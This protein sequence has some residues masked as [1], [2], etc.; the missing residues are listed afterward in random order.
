MSDL[1]RCGDHVLHHPTGE[2]WVV[3][4]AEGDDLAWAGWPNG[5]ARLADCTVIKHC[6]DAEH[7]RAVQ[8]WAD[9][10][11]GDSRRPRVLRLYAAVL[12]LTP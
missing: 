12:E 8:E 3:A 11:R 2:E 5:L 4:W 10:E 6:S 9:M 1:P 7:R